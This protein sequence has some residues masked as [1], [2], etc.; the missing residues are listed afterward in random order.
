MVTIRE[1]KKSLALKASSSFDDEEDDL[2]EF[3]AI[4][5]MDKMALLS[6]ML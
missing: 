4:D 5:K 1:K 6:K 3:E 2:N